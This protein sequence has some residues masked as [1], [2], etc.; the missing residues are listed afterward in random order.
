[1]GACLRGT[2][3]STIIP[4]HS[5]WRRASGRLMIGE[6]GTRCH[7]F[8]GSRL[9]DR[10]DQ[11]PDGGSCICVDREGCTACDLRSSNKLTNAQGCEET[12]RSRDRLIPGSGD[13]RRTR[14]SC[15]R[16]DVLTL[17]A[18]IIMARP[19]RLKRFIASPD[20]YGERGLTRS[21]FSDRRFLAVGRHPWF[22]KSVFPGHSLVPAYCPE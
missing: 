11:N 10:K 5:S 2:S 19:V 13:C 22:I 18:F 17:R 20:H 7:G 12:A 8:V 4:R 14:A 21:G 6:P 1:M 16:P 9:T 15:G 3:G